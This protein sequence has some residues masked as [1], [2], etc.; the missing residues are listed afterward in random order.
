MMAKFCIYTM[1][2]T[3]HEARIVDVN[4]LTSGYVLLCKETQ[5][6]TLAVIDL[7]AVMYL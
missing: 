6:P 5:A 4:S 7:P 3:H 2:L 1:Q